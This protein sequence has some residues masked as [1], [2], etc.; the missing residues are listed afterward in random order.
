LGREAQRQQRYRTIRA[1]PQTAAA[2]KPD[3]VDGFDI[4]FHPVLPRK[5][6]MRTRRDI[7]LRL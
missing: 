1:T 2:A 6:C 7:P 5:F 4:Q 3:E